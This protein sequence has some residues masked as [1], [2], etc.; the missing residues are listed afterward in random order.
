M[1]TP[2]TRECPWNFAH[3]F[4]EPLPSLS[5]M[6]CF[7]IVRCLFFLFFLGYLGLRPSLMERFW[8]AKKISE[9]LL[10]TCFHV[11]HTRSRTE[12]SSLFSEY[13][14][15]FG[16]RYLLIDSFFFSPEGHRSILLLCCHFRRKNQEAISTYISTFQSKMGPI[17]RVNRVLNWFWG[18]WSMSTFFKTISWRNGNRRWMPLPKWLV[19]RQGKRARFAGQPK[20]G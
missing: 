9:N 10:S 12:L 19:G 8:E 5:R 18:N 16:E 4:N 17:F 3:A 20:S 1:S 2:F 13:L 6:C 15:S 7:F 11:L 14:R